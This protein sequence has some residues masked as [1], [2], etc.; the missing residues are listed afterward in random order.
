MD[1]QI[2]FEKYLVKEKKSMNNLLISET[3]RGKKSEDDE[4]KTA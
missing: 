3:E 4:N 2:I 1:S